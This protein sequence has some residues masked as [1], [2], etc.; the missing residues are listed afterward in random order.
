MRSSLK[1]HLYRF[2][3]S[4]LVKMPTVRAAPFPYSPLEPYSIRL[5]AGVQPA[6]KTSPPTFSLEHFS[7]TGLPRYAALSYCWGSSVKTATVIVNGQSVAVTQNLA[8]ALLDL[9]NAANLG[10]DH[11]D[12]RVRHLWVDALCIDQS[13]IPE[14]DEQVALMRDIYHYA[15]IVLAYMGPEQRQTKAAFQA[16]DR[17]TLPSNFSES[18][19]IMRARREGGGRSQPWDKA[20]EAGVL[21]LQSE[22]WR[23]TW[24]VQG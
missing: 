3:K 6:T 16:L 10:T 13:N 1:P 22:Y 19:P 5:I 14:R 15:N 21:L 24:I 7:L 4:P 11:I 8:S 17:W 2:Q 20:D 23:R 12:P 18:L 9:A